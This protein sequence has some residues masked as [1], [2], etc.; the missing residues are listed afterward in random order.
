MKSKRGF[1]HFIVGEQDFIVVQ[2][3]EDR[4][5]QFSITFDEIDELKELKDKTVQKRRHVARVAVMLCRNGNCDGDEQ[6]CGGTE[7]RGPRWRWWSHEHFA[8]IFDRCPRGCKP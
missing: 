5:A 1:L 3:N 6:G 4:S 2:D 7:C 8:R